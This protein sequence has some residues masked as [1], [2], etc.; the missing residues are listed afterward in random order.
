MARRQ[1]PVP[2]PGELSGAS[3]YNLAESS[4]SAAWKPVK[5]DVLKSLSSRSNGKPIEPYLPNLLEQ[6]GLTQL[7]ICIAG[8]YAS[9]CAP[10]LSF[11]LREAQSQ[12]L[13]HF[14]HLL[15]C[16]VLSLLAI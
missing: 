15:T 14:L 5:E 11:S 3:N 16:S 4:S 1:K 13:Y 12:S 9:L 7:I 10:L 2:S 6:P 8:I